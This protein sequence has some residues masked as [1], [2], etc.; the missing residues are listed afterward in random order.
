MKVVPPQMWNL[1]SINSQQSQLS[2]TQTHLPAWQCMEPMWFSWQ[3]AVVLHSFASFP[4]CH[5]LVIQRLLDD[6]L[7]NSETV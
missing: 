7:K 1:F 3:L 2:S 6:K 5:L 4:G